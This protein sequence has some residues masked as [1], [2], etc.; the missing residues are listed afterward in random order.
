[1]LTT[2]CLQELLE[3]DATQSFD[4]ELV[5]DDTPVSFSWDCQWVYDERT[6]THK[7]STSQSSLCLLTG[8][9]VARTDYFADN[10]PTV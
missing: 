9:R 3:L 10:V 4:F 2:K 5:D 7:F 1:M 6:D 8:G